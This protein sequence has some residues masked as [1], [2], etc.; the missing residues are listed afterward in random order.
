MVSTQIRY[1][2]DESDRTKLTIL[3]NRFAG[4]RCVIIGNGPSLNDVSLKLLKDEHTFGV[5]SIFLKQDSEAFVPSFYVIEDN[6]VVEDN[7]D[8]INVFRSEERAVG[9][10]GRYRGVL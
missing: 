3:K 6:H 2:T 1:Q 4:Q 5:N 10:G 7:I 9:K 8:R